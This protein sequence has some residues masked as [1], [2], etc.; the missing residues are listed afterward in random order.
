MFQ[1]GLSQT[2]AQPHSWAPGPTS[3]LRRGPTSWHT[4]RAFAVPVPV[5]LPPLPPSLIA[6]TP[7]RT[8]LGLYVCPKPTI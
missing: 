5:F 6:T 4:H 7:V 1:M 8:S 3:R 2:Q